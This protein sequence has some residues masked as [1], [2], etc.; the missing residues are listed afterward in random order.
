[1][2]TFLSVAMISYVLLQ[3]VMYVCLAAVEAKPAKE[4]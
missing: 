2:T 1:M 4:S 3:A